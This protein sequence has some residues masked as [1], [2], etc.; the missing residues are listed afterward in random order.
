VAELAVIKVGRTWSPIPLSADYSGLKYTLVGL[1]YSL[2]FDLLVIAGLLVNVRNGGLPKAAKVLLV[3]PAIYFTLV[4]AL[5]V[6]SLRY[7]IPAEPPMAILAAG[8]AAVAARHLLPG[9]LDRW[10]RATDV[11]NSE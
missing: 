9:R 5:S 6:G 11:R 10:K 4:H 7:R 8:G 3:T 2:P 1:L